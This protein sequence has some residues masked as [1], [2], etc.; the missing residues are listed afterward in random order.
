M[1]NEEQ[2]NIDN[3][4]VTKILV[5]ID[6]SDCSTLALRYAAKMALICNAHITVF[7]SFYSPAYDLIE[8][9]G[10]KTTQEQLREKVT[11]K[12]YI[13][14][15]IDMELY[16][17]NLSNLKEIQDLGMGKITYKLVPGLP[18]DQL[19]KMADS[20]NPNVIVM[21]TR[22]VDKKSKSILGSVTEI[23][24]RKMSYP[25]LAI[26][27]EYEFIGTDNITSIVYLTDFDESDFQSI[28]YLSKFT[29]LLNLEI[30][31]IHIGPKSDK[32]DG[33]KMNGLKQY[34]K[35][36][37]DIETTV[38]SIIE[39]KGTLIEDLDNYVIENKINLIS[40]TTKKRRLYDKVFKP[41]ITEQLFYHTNLPL[42][43]FHS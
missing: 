37:Y 27:E 40:L 4:N 26:P 18:K 22:G 39:K 15:K 5:P 11:E 21:G 13:N 36:V 7:H 10:N 28:S 16:L 43:V 38:C 20:L 12:L 24:I 30:H 31:C 2:K 23:A 42:L 35:N 8:L 17:K 9:T 33:L 32:W 6:Y 29:K 3:H 14:E 41:N 25:V 34:F 19:F 1:M